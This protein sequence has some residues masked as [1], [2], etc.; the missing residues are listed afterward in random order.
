MYLLFVQSNRMLTMGES[1]SPGARACTAAAENAAIVLPDDV[2]GGGR[3]AATAVADDPPPVPA[4]ST[5]LRLLPAM[6]SSIR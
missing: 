3:A 5:T 6:S 4:V 2:G 1:K